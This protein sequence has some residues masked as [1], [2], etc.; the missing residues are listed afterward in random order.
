MVLMLC[1]INIVLINKHLSSS[2]R[3]RKLWHVYSERQGAL[4]RDISEL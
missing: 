3:E 2:L 4:R 1:E